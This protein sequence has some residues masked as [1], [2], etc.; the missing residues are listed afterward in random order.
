MRQRQGIHPLARLDGIAGAAPGLDEPVLVPCMGAV[1]GRARQGVAAAAAQGFTDGPGLRGRLVLV[2]PVDG[3]SLG[4]IGEGQRKVLLPGPFDH[5]PIL[6]GDQRL[7]PHIVPRARAGVPL[8]ELDPPGN[9]PARRVLQIQIH[10]GDVALPP[11]RE[12]DVGIMGGEGHG[13]GIEAVQG[14]E[15]A[16]NQVHPVRVHQGDHMER[17]GLK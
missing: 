14:A 7:A 11:V 1:D 3:P 12:G 17:G 15:G 6:R 9:L 2:L 4:V 16:R 8:A 13:L 10:P 5:G